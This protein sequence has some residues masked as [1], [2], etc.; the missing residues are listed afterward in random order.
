MTRILSCGVLCAALFLAFLPRRAVAGVTNPDISFL[1]QM[2]TFLTDDPADINRK[3]AQISFDETEVVADAALNPYA[4]GVFVLS[5]ADG[6]IEVEEGYM[7]LVRGLPT[8]FKFRAGKYRIGFGKLNA[9]H[10]HAYPFIDRFRVLAAYLPGDESFNEPGAQ[11][12][13]R[14]PL[15]GDVSS[16]VSAD[17]LQGNTFH[18]DESAARPAVVARWSNFFLLKD[19]SALDVGVSFAQGTNNVANGTRTNLF[20]VEAKAKLWSSPRSFLVLQGEMIAMD[21]ATGAFDSSTATLTKSDA[22]RIGG[23]VFGDFTWNKRC[24]F[25]AKY[26]GYQRPELGPNGKKAWDQSAGLFAGLALM[27]ETTLFRFAWDRFVPQH[28]SA[29]NTFT[30]QLVFS[31]GPHKAHQF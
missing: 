13:Y 29:Y 3:R 7:D 6:S 27:E 19:P 16:T 25:G 10:P 4:H 12:S 17:V 23:Y 9:V 24:N 31:M 5:V 15:P 30:L 21:R 18:P 14:L 11:L 22:R 20:G 28:E 8:G 1:G 2:R 26:E